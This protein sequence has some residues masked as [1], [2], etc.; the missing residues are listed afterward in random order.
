MHFFLLLI[1]AVSALP[2]SPDKLKTSDPIFVQ[3]LTM[4]ALKKYMNFP[5]TTRLTLDLF[6]PWMADTRS[7]VLSKCITSETLF[8]TGGDKESKVVVTGLEKSITENEGLCL[9]RLHYLNQEGKVI[10]NS[11]S[12]DMEKAMDASKVI[13]VPS[14]ILILEKSVFVMYVDVN[15]TSQR[16]ETP[17]E[18]MKDLGLKLQR[19]GDKLSIV[20]FGKQFYTTPIPMKW[21]IDYIV[22]VTNTEVD[23][24]GSILK[25]APPFE[26]IAQNK[27]KPTDKIE[28]LN[29]MDTSLPLSVICKRNETW[30]REGPKIQT[31]VVKMNQFTLSIKQPTENCYL[32]ND[33]GF[34]IG[35]HTTVLPDDVE[36]PATEENFLERYSLYIYCGVGALGLLIIILVCVCSCKKSK[37]SKKGTKQTTTQRK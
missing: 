35:L 31:N 33:F 16:I 5:N 32:C 15:G 7:S 22:D 18:D 27:P 13:E 29:G 34:C 11:D 14:A 12:F 8:E 37:R 36:K 10:G 19:K 4:D 9:Y 30:S 23:M 20:S 21:Q 6:E 17:F 2:S 3:I 1:T 28:W 24:V 26:S 25:V